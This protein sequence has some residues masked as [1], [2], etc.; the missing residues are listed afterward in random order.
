MKQ[1]NRLITAISSLVILLTIGYIIM[2]IRHIGGFLFEELIPLLINFLIV[3]PAILGLQKIRHLET[4]RTTIIGFVIYGLAVLFG[5][6]N[7]F[8]S[9]DALAAGLPMVVI[10]I[11]I[12]LFFSMYL[13]SQIK[14]K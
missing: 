7:V 14:K 9:D 11:P 10:V 6:I 4:N 1:N 13:L 5:F 3:I 12:S 8:I 2:A